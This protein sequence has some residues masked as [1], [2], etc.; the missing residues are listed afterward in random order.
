MICE[1]YFAVHDVPQGKETRCSAVFSLLD[2]SVQALSFSN[3]GTKLAIGFSS[4]RVGII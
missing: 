2:S 3:S 1:I 4:G